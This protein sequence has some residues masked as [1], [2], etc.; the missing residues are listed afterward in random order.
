MTPGTGR[1]KLSTEEQ[2]V[3]V[4]ATPK[5]VRRTA[6]E[7]RRLILDA[8]EKRL[9]E[10]G[11]EG[12]RLQDIARDVGISH[13]AILHHFESRDGL[14]RALIR[15]ATEQ[16]K[17]KLF[18]AIP[19]D[20]STQEPESHSLELIESAFEALSDRG[21]ARLLSWLLLTNAERAKPVNPSAALLKDVSEKLHDQRVSFAKERNTPAPSHEDTVFMAMLTAYA[22]V[23]EA[24]M[25][26]DFYQA[27]GLDDG[28]G[29]IAHRFRGWLATL[30]ERHAIE[31]Y[32]DDDCKATL[33]EMQAKKNGAQG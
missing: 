21:T 28:D 6:E 5:R 4:K 25:G 8:A 30:L 3:V 7:A 14:V 26:R 2:A 10:Q 15:R 12:I 16:L 19:A 18:S 23:G 32:L 27:A 24:I 31:P 17:E 11:P 33:R 22:A 1:D 20:V 13:P 29:D 9:A